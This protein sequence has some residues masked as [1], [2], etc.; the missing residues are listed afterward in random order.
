MQDVL[1]FFCLLGNMKNASFYSLYKDS[2]G[3]YAAQCTTRALTYAIACNFIYVDTFFTKFFN[4]ANV[5][6]Y[7]LEKIL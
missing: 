4:K 6:V 7:K 2:R 5:F 1:F 3:Y